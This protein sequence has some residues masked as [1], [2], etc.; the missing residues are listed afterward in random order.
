MTETVEYVNT[1]LIFM[2]FLI[3]VLF[4]FL[5]FLRKSGL[6]M[7]WILFL[8]FAQLVAYVINNYIDWGFRMSFYFEFGMMYAYSFFYAKLKYRANKIVLQSF[9]IVSLLFYFTYK[10]YI[11]GNCQIIPY[12]FIWSD[13][14]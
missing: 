1:N 14:L 10:F 7:L 4:L 13:H 12:Q 9:L 2:A 5:R 6:D 3:L 11:Q 8:C